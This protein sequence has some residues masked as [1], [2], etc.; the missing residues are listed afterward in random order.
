MIKK[1]NSK[2]LDIKKTGKKIKQIFLEKPQSVKFK[3]GQ[4]ISIQVNEK[5]KIRKPYSIASINSD[6]FLEICAKDLRGSGSNYLFSLK[7]GMKVNYIFPMGDFTIKSNKKNIIF[8]A[9]GTGVVP[10]K[11]MILELLENN[12]SK[13]IILIRGVRFEDELTYEDYFL[14]LEK[15]YKNFKHH[16]IVSQPKTKKYESHHIQDLMFEIIPKKFKGHF[17]LCGISEMIKSVSKKLM[18]KGTKRKD[19]FYEEYD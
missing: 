17:Y 8:I 16:N 19:I 5:T 2:V 3:P 6:D 10:F 9:T 15:K 11:S 4:Y 1:Y 12:F 18:N 13:N 14:D 7:K